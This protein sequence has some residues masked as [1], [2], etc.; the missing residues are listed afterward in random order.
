LGGR[1]ARGSL[2]HRE[3]IPVH[4]KSQLLDFSKATNRKR[5]HTI[6]TQ[7]KKDEVFVSVKVFKKARQGRE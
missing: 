3:I 2:K 7:K 6:G 1:E 5:R 4:F